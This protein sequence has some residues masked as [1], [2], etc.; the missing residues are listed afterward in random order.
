MKLSAILAALAD[1]KLP[2]VTPEQLRPLV[3]TTE[4]KAFADDVRC[5]AAG[6]TTRRH[7]L[8][9]VVHALDPRVQG[10]VEHMGL[11]FDLLVLIGAARRDGD[12]LF[13]AIKTAATDAS[14]RAET[15]G[16]LCGIGLKMA[17]AIAK[18]D[19]PYY[20]FKLFGGSAALCVS[21]ARTRSSNQCTVQIEGALLLGGGNRKEFDWRNKIVVQLT[22][23]EAYLTLALLENLIP[24]VRF[25]GHGRA[26]DKSL[27]IECQGPHYFVRL[28]QRGHPPVAV[29]VRAVDALPI[30][31]LLYKQLLRNDP[32]LRIEDIRRMV[33]RMAHMIKVPH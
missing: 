15:V 20:S 21:E 14:T 9:A 32:H 3:G 31:A 8:A 6:D 4:G 13:K 5:F 29:P 22:V 17:P 11:H 1:A 23:Q 30:I 10:A 12:R 27:Y 33:E 24:S 16:Y 25:D 18:A 2:S 26:H 28:I 19:P 7:G